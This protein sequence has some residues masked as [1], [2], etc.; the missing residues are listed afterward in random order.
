MTQHLVLNVLSDV[1]V[2]PQPLSP[3]G[4]GTNTVRDAASWFFTS[5]QRQLIVQQEMDSNVRITCMATWNPWAGP[6]MTHSPV[7][8]EGTR[9]LLQLALPALLLMSN[10]GTAAEKK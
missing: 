5:N 8:S 2:N 6:N 3:A 1:T 4:Q 7:L 10:L 9:V